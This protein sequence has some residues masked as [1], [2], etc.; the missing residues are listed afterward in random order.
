MLT[1]FKGQSFQQIAKFLLTGGM[2]TFIDFA[3]LNLLILIFGLTQGD[4]H[5]AIFKACSYFVASCNS[6]IFNKVWVFKSDGAI[7]KEQTGKRLTREIGSFAVVSLIGLVL[8]TLISLSVFHAASL[9]FPT[10]GSQVLAN[11]G[12]IVGT[13]VVLVFNFLTYK[14]FI[15]TTS[16]TT[17]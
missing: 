9:L 4:P 13:G 3:V 16:S 8:N 5:Y 1:L 12:A 15:F 7:G 14:F 6:F 10:I 11:V 2:N 17:I